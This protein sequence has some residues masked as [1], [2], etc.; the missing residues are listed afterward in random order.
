M[1][2]V[3]HILSLLTLCRETDWSWTSFSSVADDARFSYVL[4]IVDPLTVKVI[5]LNISFW[6]KEFYFLPVLE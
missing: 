6:F 2:C 4:Y 3:N 5:V 1:Y